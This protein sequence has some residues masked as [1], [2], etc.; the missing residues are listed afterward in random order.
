MLQWKKKH[1]HMLGWG[2]T[3]DEG[4]QDTMPVYDIDEDYSQKKVRSPVYIS[5]FQ[6]THPILIQIRV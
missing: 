1:C 2:K 5:S 3:E 4:T 6:S